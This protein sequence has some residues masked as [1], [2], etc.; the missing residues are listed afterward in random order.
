MSLS[1]DA[2]IQD[3]LE[4]TGE[5]MFFSN[6]IDCLIGHKLGVIRDHL[7]TVRGDPVLRMKPEPRKTNNTSRGNT[8]SW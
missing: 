6:E 3:F 4:I 5:E 8:D 7:A 2:Q 1:N